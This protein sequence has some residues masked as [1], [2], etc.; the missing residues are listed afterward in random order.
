MNIDGR[1]DWVTRADIGPYCVRPSRGQ[2]PSF[3]AV[4]RMNIDRRVRSVYSYDDVVDG[5]RAGL[6]DVA[7]C[8]RLFCVEAKHSRCRRLP[9]TATATATTV[10]SSSTL[11][12]Y[13]PNIG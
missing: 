12:N 2:Q 8:R 4:R 9:V 5:E 11:C 10:H 13:S 6:C 1:S 7:V 3:S